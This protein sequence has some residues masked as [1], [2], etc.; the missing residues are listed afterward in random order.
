MMDIALTLDDLRARDWAAILASAASKE[1]SAYREAFCAR[2]EQARADG[3]EKDRLVFQLFS[4]ICS[5]GFEPRQTIDPFPSRMT[6]GN[7]SWPIPS[8]IAENDLVTLGQLIADIQDPELRARIAD[9]L[10]VRKRD[11]RHAELAIDA[12]LSSALILENGPAFEF[13]VHRIERALRLSVMLRN[14]ELFNRVVSHIEAVI[15]RHQSNE[16]LRCGH[17]MELL[18]E[19]HEV[20]AT[21][22]AARTKASAEQAAAGGDFEAARRLWLLASPW[23][24]RAKDE[25]SR[26]ASLAAAA[27]TYVSQAELSEKGTPPNYALVCHHLGMAIDQYKRIGGHKARIDELHARLEGLAAS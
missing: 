14:T 17:L 13:S 9:L 11:H 8:D 2:A 18:M 5:F 22:Q 20:D 10:W 4:H 21:A 15:D 1:C 23:F 6:C 19:F 16:P 24:N 27:E 26:K 7:A 3:K 25:T 12:Y